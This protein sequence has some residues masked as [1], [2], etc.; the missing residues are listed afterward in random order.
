MKCTCG[1]AKGIGR[2]CGTCQAAFRAEYPR[3]RTERVHAH[4]PNRCP[5]H[6]AWV[7]S[8]ACAVP[9]CREKDIHAHHVRE[10]S[11]GGM[12]LKPGDE[13][14]V[15]LCG[16]HHRELHYIGAVSFDMLYGVNL[17]AR[18]EALAERS[19]HLKAR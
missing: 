17:R 6:L 9:V 16:A 3:R 2:L 1:R 5:K 7:R 15:G 19:P 4:D 14:V 13:W 12:G 10:R 18:A 11:G 8:F